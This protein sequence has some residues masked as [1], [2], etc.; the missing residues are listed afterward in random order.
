MS[1]PKK[2][3]KPKRAKAK[4][5]PKPK[6]PKPKKPKNKKA[7]K[8]SEGDPGPIPRAGE[9]EPIPSITPAGDPSICNQPL[10]EEGETPQ[11]EGD[12]VPLGTEP[13]FVNVGEIPLPPGMPPLRCE[14]TPT[15]FAERTNAAMPTIS[16]ERAYAP[17]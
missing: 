10:P 14:P 2:D 12:P 11:P 7:R 17:T 6:Y 8:Q 5:E 16:A 3:P 13:Q 9:E 1:K 4:K 15:I